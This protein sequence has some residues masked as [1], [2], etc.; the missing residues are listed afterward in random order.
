VQDENPRSL[1]V[2]DHELGGAGRAVR[3]GVPRVEVAD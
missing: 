2:L 1:D 3:D